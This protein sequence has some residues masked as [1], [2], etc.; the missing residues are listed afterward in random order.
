[1]PILTEMIQVFNTIL[2]KAT[3][4]YHSSC[5]SPKSPNQPLQQTKRYTLY[6]VAVLNFFSTMFP[7]ELDL[8]LK[9]S[10]VNTVSRLSA[11][12]LKDRLL[13]K[14][15]RKLTL[16][17]P[18]VWF[19]LHLSPMLKSGSIMLQFY[20]LNFLDEFFEM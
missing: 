7:S 15:E 6:R 12:I 10:L 3:S 16:T 13:Q 18:F 4:A 9:R 17:S 14:K 20:P 19:H 8:H 5:A 1:M 2:P 11:S